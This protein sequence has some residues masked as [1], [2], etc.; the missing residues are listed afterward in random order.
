MLG[1][2]IALV[3][4]TFTV[5][6]APHID[7]FF[8]WLGQ[9]IPTKPAV[10]IEN[11]GHLEANRVKRYL[12]QRFVAWHQANRIWSRGRAFAMLQYLAQ[13]NCPLFWLSSKNIAWSSWLLRV[14]SSPL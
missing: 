2:F 4:L 13:K 8:G 6:L 3:I 9:G 1:F 14:Q 10:L 7:K 5:I 12:I 11:T